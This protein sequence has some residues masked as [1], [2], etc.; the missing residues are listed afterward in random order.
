M[1][2]RLGAALSLGCALALA[3]PAWA[4]SI[5]SF[6][7]EVALAPATD[8]T[9]EERIAWDFGS[10][11]RHGIIREIPLSY[12]RE[13][14]A[15]W[16]LRIDVES[17][18]DG[19][20]RPLQ[21][22]ERERRGVL[23][24]RIGDPDA[25]VTGVQEYRIRYRV[26]R[27][28]QYFPDHDELYWNVT[29][30]QWRVPIQ[31]AS[32]S[33]ALPPGVDAAAVRVTCFAGPRGSSLEDCTAS[34]SGDTARFVA[35]G[36]LAP[37]SG[38]TLVVGLPKG[39][40]PEPSALSRF[41]DR[42]TDY[43]S[44]WL[45]LPIGAF[46]LLYRK[47]S[48][49]GRDPSGVD[50]I[51]VRYEPPAGLAPAEMGT[52]VDE[53]ADNEDL[54]ATVLDLAVRGALRIEEEETKRFLFLSNHDYRLVRT[55]KDVELKPFEERLLS[56]LFKGAGEEVRISELRNK[57]YKELPA[58]RDALYK[59]LTH[60]ETG[61]FPTSP[62]KVRKRWRT[63]GIVTAGVGGLALMADAS[64]VAIGSLVV[65]GLIVLAFGSAMPRRT[66]KGRRACDEIL[67]FREFLQRVDADRLERSG[68]RTEG[69]FERILPYAVVLGAADAWAEA[70]EGIYTTPP[71]WYRSDSGGMFSTNRFVSDVGRSLQTMGQALTSAPS[72]GGG[73]SG[74]SGGSSGGGFGGGGGG[75]W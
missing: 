35:D 52:V 28:L 72:S 12:G 50:A 60:G 1:L 51:P 34:V 11:R 31:S 14:A 22:Q 2:A 66:R 46:A 59:G 10:E 19:A 63:I 24:V 42:F 18:T 26:E 56:A 68:G 49:D 3:T 32:A 41:W 9:V 75:S 37:G 61:Y 6:D 65:T 43:V 64:L 8:F 74:F 69:R 45:L 47:W 58:I 36:S 53:R 5:R 70:F 54:T 57:F 17:V 73:S 40:L 23:S 13:H 48:R 15:S 30:D 38:L 62:E 27:A 67:G 7:V 21:W 29:G 39:A 20:G 25:F 16:N 55:G 71:S 33:V 44:L 4:E